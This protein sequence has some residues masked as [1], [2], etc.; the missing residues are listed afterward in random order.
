VKKL[1]RYIDDKLVR[2]KTWLLIFFK[3]FIE[4]KKRYN[5]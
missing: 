4:I 2:G 5:G 3:E 1:K